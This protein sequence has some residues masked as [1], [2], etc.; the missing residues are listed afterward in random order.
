MV[1]STAG[2]LNNKSET[3]KRCKNTADFS[4]MKCTTV[5]WYRKHKTKRNT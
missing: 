2:S 3:S 1:L 5:L 4:S